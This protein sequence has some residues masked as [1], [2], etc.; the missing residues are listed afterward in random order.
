MNVQVTTGR[1][2]TMSLDE[3]LGT[4]RTFGSVGPTYEVLSIA[5]PETGSDVRLSIRVVTTGEELDYALADA[6]ADPLAR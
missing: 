6:L 2:V 3:I 4:F 5:G 1:T